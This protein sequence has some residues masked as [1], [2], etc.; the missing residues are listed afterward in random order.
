MVQVPVVVRHGARELTGAVRA[1]ESWADAAGRIATTVPGDPVADDLSGDVLRFAVDP[2]QRIVLR[3]MTR[4]DL[5]ILSRW[6]AAEHVRRWWHDTEPALDR[7]VAR[8]GP[9]IDGTTPTRMWVVDLN[10]HSIGFVQDYR[11]RDHPDFALLTPDPDAVGL[12]YAIGEPAWVGRGLGARILWT[13]MR[14]ARHRFPDATAYFAAPHHANAA[15]LRTLDKA[16]FVQGTWFDEPQRG[17]GVETVVGCT[18]DVRR[19]L[20]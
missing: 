12:D 17:G 8:Y 15:S 19:V 20:G 3:A 6:L 14:R 9:R 16:G 13:W 10:G 5:P 1:G 7:V 2:D 11:I 18:L 4:G